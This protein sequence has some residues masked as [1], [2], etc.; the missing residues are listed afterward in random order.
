MKAYL[1]IVVFLIISACS[2]RQEKKSFENKKNNSTGFVKDTLINGYQT[3][4]SLK[5]DYLVKETE[6]ELHI[7]IDNVPQDQIIIYTK[8]SEAKVKQSNNHKNF[9]VIPT[10]SSSKVTINLNTQT[11]GQIIKIG[12]IDIKTKSK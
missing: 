7:R 1:A 9:I 10:K 8:T 5:T 2:I 11:D 6:N 3:N 12:E 4:I